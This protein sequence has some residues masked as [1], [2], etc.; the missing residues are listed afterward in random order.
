MWGWWSVWS[1]RKMLQLQPPVVHMVGFIWSNAWTKKYTSLMHHICPLW[2]ILTEKITCVGS[3]NACPF[4]QTW[5]FLKK[6]ISA[7]FFA[8]PRCHLWEYSDPCWAVLP[9][10]CLL[11]HCWDLFITFHSLLKHAPYFSLPVIKTACWMLCT[12]QAMNRS[13]SITS[14]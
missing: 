4:C 7:Y 12:I 1:A 14:N 11:K 9:K 8:L 10:S 2:I 3:C 6:Y 13:C 5:K